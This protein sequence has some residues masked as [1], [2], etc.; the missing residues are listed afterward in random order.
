MNQLQHDVDSIVY[1][2]KANE[3]FLSQVQQTLR[4]YVTDKSFPIEDRFR[5]WSKYCEKEHETWV[6]HR[7]EF[8]IIGDM[9][10]DCEPYEYIRGKTYTWDWFYDNIDSDVKDFEETLIETNFG[11]FVNDW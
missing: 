7:G 4:Q 10:A 1:T 5:V 6:I 11:S 2:L 3:R 9:V 8:G